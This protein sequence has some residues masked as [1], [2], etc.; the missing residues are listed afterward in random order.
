MKQPRRCA[1]NQL[2]VKRNLEMKH[3]T[4]WAKYFAIAALMGGSCASAAFA[5]TGENCSLALSQTQI[6]YGNF[7]HEY[8]QATSVDGKSASAGRQE[9]SVQVSC[10]RPVRLGLRITGMGAET[11]KTIQF[12]TADEGHVIATLGPAIVNERPIQQWR[13]LQANKQNDIQKA[14]LQLQADETV[15]PLASDGTEI[16]VST[17]QAKLALSPQLN[18]QGKSGSAQAIMSSNIRI[19]IIEL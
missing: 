18:L 4:K 8:L 12:G 13:V 15:V 7:T 5:Q 6:D 17:L 11:E 3:Y 14:D 19:S 10:Q 9:L 16:L 1:S 2:I